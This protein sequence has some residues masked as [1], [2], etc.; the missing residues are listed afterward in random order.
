MREELVKLLEV[1]RETERSMNVYMGYLTNK[2]Y[3]IG[4]LDEVRLIISDLEKL[5]EKQ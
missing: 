3:A 1:Y 2:D 4:K 5:I